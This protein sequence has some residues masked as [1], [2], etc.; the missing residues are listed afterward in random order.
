VSAVLFRARDGRVR[1]SLKPY[2]DKRL[3]VTTDRWLPR[4]VSRNNAF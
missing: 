3:D 4:D 1:E 2:F